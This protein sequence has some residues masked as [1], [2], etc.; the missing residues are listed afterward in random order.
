MRPI[1]NLIAPKRFLAFIALLAI[2]TW[3]ASRDVPFERAAMIGFDIAAF[4]FLLMI[5]PLLSRRDSAHMRESS[6]LN[7]ANRA[8][9]LVVSGAVIAAILV[10]VGSEVTQKSQLH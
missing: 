6:R 1:G 9:L 7:D 2:A 5:A 3:L 8:T 4:G 10:A